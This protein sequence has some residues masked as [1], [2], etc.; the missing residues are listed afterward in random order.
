MFID[1]WQPQKMVKGNMQVEQRHASGLVS[2]LSYHTHK[3]PT[4]SATHKYFTICL[5]EPV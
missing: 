2:Q 3:A 4:P 5:N 1:N